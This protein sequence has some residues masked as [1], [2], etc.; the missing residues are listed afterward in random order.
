MNNLHC[1]K[2]KDNLQRCKMA[3]KKFI[4][5]MIELWRGAVDFLSHQKL[6]SYPDGFY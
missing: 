3:K 4:I 5:A 2:I 1:G 6:S